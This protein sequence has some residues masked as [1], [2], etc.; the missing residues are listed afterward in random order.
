MLSIGVR[1]SWFVVVA[2][3]E[4]SFE[5]LPAVWSVLSTTVASLPTQESW[6]LWA[7][8]LTASSS[9][10]SLNISSTLDHPV[11]AVRQA[12]NSMNVLYTYGW[13]AFVAQTFGGKRRAWIGQAVVTVARRQSWVQVL[14]TYSGDAQMSCELLCGGHLRVRAVGSMDTDNHAIALWNAVVQCGTKRL[15]FQLCSQCHAVVNSVELSQECISGRLFVTYGRGWKVFFGPKSAE[16][17]RN[18]KTSLC[19]LH[20]IWCRTCRHVR[21]STVSKRVAW[22]RVSLW[23]VTLTVKVRRQGNGAQVNVLAANVHNAAV[24]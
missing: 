2:L 13:V 22:C 4:G 21:H 12:A 8:G 20:I 1:F 5:H 14:S 6:T 23:P 15:R 16:V 17:S 7:S 9:K 3:Y 18:T 19:Y 10:L 11:K 24:S